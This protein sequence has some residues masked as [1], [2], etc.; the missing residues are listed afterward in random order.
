MKVSKLEK[1]N[2]ELQ[3]KINMSEFSS[4]SS[5]A[6]NIDSKNVEDTMLKQAL[7]DKMLAENK[8]VVDALY[9][10]TNYDTRQDKLNM[11]I[12]ET[13]KEKMLNT[14]KAIDMHEAQI[15]SRLIGYDA[16]IKFQ[17]SDKITVLNLVSSSTSIE[18]TTTKMK[19]V[20]LIDFYNYDNTWKVS[21]I[22]FIDTK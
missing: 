22:S 21:N 6:E 1:Q 13:L 18:K 5:S 11:Y 7:S 4:N 9:N 16:Y 12:T 8:K 3:E 19:T 14:T 2:S 10:Y 20:V 15:E 17:T